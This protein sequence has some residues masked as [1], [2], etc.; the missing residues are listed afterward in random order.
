M[1]AMKQGLQVIYSPR[2]RCCFSSSWEQMKFQDWNNE[3]F[4]LLP[5]Q[6]SLFPFTVLH[7]LL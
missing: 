5:I 4:V 7:M 1:G 6:A 3:T 2:V